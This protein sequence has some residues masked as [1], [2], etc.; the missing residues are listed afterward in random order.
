VSGRFLVRVHRDH[1]D[2]R[3]PYILAEE[4]AVAHPLIFR[5][6]GRVGGLFPRLE[7]TG[8]RDSRRLDVRVLKGTSAR[9]VETSRGRDA[10]E[11]AASAAGVK[12]VCRRLREREAAQ[13]EAVDAE[14]ARLEEQLAAARG[15]REKAVRSAWTKAN[16][17]RLAEMEELARRQERRGTRQG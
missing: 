17:V 12:K 11:S 14:I 1:G 16:V 8:R 6:V 2:R 7:S 10:V 5:E 13:L 4:I 3:S 15:R 9:G